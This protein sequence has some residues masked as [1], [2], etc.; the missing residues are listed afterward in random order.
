[1]P[2]KQICE[3]HQ[4]FKNYWYL[5]NL[6]CNYCVPIL[7]CLTL[8]S[9]VFIRYYSGRLC[10][11]IYIYLSAVVLA[12]PKFVICCDKYFLKDK[13]GIF[14]GLRGGGE[15]YRKVPVF[16]QLVMVGF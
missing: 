7:Q 11:K 1:M 16:S 13:T 4:S 5:T 14:T 8:K 2:K 15:L 12:I 6:L 3:V 9:I 10:I